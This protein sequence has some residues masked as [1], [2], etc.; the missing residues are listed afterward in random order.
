MGNPRIQ[1][2]NIGGL[3]GGVVPNM[4]PTFL[5]LDGTG[6]EQIVGD[7]S[8]T[9]GSFYIQP[10]A[11]EI[12]IVRRF[13]AYLEDGAPFITTKFGDLTARTNGLKIRVR[14][15]GSWINWFNGETIKDNGD[16]LKHLGWSGGSFPGQPAAF[17]L[18][19]AGLD[20]IYLGLSGDDEDR[21]EVLAQDDFSGLVDHCY[22]ALVYKVVEP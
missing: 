8:E 21:L 15:A 1:I 14:R 5:R 22:Q 9:P 10:P 6:T 2:G 11:G 18:I 20:N 13:V 17:G 7:Y 19:A 12:W 16:L 4:L 3:L